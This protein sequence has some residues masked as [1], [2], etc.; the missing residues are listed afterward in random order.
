M[1]DLTELLKS[2]TV[3]KTSPFANI[4]I[5][6]I[7]Y[8]SRTVGQGE[9][10]IAIKGFKTDGHQFIDKAIAN[11]AVAI[12]IENE[13]FSTDKCPWILVEN[14]RTA[15]ADL[16][17]A[18]YNYPS[19]EL[20]LIGVTGT[21]GKTTTA[22]L[23]AK[24]FA[25]QGHKIG[26]IGTIH[27]RIGD[28]ILPGERT[29][30]E[31]SDLQYLFKEMLADGVGVVVMEVSSHALDL[32]RVRGCDFDVAVFTNLTQDHL[33][34]HQTMEE[35]YQAKAKLFINL[36]N[37]DSRRKDKFAVINGDDPWGQKL[38]ADT[39]VKVLSYGIAGNVSLKAENIKVT[40]AGVNY[41]IQDNCLKLKL[42]GKF[43]VYNSLA[44]LAVAV[45]KGIPI[46]R[47][48]ASL[49]EVAGIPGRFQLVQGAEDF[50]VI[51][52]YAH[53]P[54]SLINI[55]TTAR[56]LTAGRIITVF[57][58]G[59]DRD[60]TKRPLMGKAAAR[61]SDYCIVTSDNPRTEDPRTIIRD[62]LPGLEEVAGEE[63][64]RVMAD[65]KKA[66][67]EALQIARKGDSVII[68]GKGH[69]TYQEINGEKYPFDDKAIAEEILKNMNK[70]TS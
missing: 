36:V 30:P 29:T 24:I 43:N 44:A 38:L 66:I 7:K 20:I 26:L 55:L 45:G 1:F 27:N 58:C 69:E 40:S 5:G 59:G 10:F 60:R 48:A 39:R 3:K 17:A 25:D 8:D 6:G 63:K 21:N 47:A 33:D 11:G 12:V 18:F 23:I 37:R 22:N 42:T 14:G 4:S 57:G 68:A 16:S 49:E 61:Y 56:E 51:V 50:A 70:A 64:Y 19:R 28:K 52:D 34:Y 32:E 9:L 53:T 54:D 15:L 62:I 65:R 31:S 41:Q 46:S 35:Y 13:S 2:T 67:Q